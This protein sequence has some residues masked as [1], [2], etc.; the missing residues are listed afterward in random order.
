MALSLRTPI[1][2]LSFP[3]LFTPRP[4]VPGGE[5][6]FSL[7]LLFDP[8]AQKAPEFAALKRAVAQAI[9]EKWGQGKS[10]DAN[11][12]K[13]LRLPFLPCKDM[14][15]DGYD[16]PGGIFIRPWTKNKPGI[17]DAQRQEITVPG[18]VWAGQNVRCTVTPFPYE[19]TGNR[20]IS[21]GLNNLQ[22]CRTDGKRLDGRKKATEDFPDDLGDASGPADDDIPF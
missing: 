11:F 17:V 7:N 16:I 3:V 1:G 12:I 21:F 18:D 5:P 20:G 22:I 15:Y 4:V 9:D 2:I 6:R 14:T 13:R 10:Q 8:T 19:Q